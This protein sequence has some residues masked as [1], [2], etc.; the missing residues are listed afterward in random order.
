VLTEI[1]VRATL[2][3][4]LGGDLGDY[5]ILGACNPPLAPGAERRPADRTPQAEGRL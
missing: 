5:L 1:D 2:G 4:K 3:E